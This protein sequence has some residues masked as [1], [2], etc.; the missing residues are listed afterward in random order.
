MNS[1]YF[2][3]SRMKARISLASCEKRRADA[4]KLRDSVLKASSMS[5]CKTC[6]GPPAGTQRV[7]VEEVMRLRE[8]DVAVSKAAK[9]LTRPL[10][11]R[12]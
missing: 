7:A 9:K 4:A 11:G 5:M 3:C 12:D 1:D 6:E 8:A 10:Y 2:D